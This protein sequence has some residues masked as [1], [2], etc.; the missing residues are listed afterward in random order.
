LQRNKCLE[1]EDK[2][3]SQF[4]QLKK[5]V[6]DYEKRIAGKKRQIAEMQEKLDN[7]NFDPEQH[8]QELQEKK[9]TIDNVSFLFIMVFNSYRLIKNMK[10][11][12]PTALISTEELSS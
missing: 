11:S 4:A 2:E 6:A 8:T 10:K 5:R 3:N 1:S 7:L 12:R 9:I